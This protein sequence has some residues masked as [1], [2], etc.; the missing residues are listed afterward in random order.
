M[1]P[2]LLIAGL[3][4]A[5]VSV[6]KRDEGSVWTVLIV[7]SLLLSGAAVAGLMKLIVAL[8]I[9]GMNILAAA[10][11]VIFISLG[12][13]GWGIVTNWREQNVKRYI[14]HLL[15]IQ[16][17]I[18]LLSVSKATHLGLA[19]GVFYFVSMSLTSLLIL[20]GVGLFYENKKCV[21]E[22]NAMSAYG[23]H[24]SLSSLILLVGFSS[25]MFL[26]PF[27]G[28]SSLLNLCAAI[29]EQHSLLSLCILIILIIG[30]WFCEIKFFSMIF[31]GEKAFLSGAGLDNKENNF[32]HLFDRALLGLIIVFLL[33]G[34]LYW[35]HLIRPLEGFAKDF[36]IS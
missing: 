23:K 13:A 1:L 14:S 28:F 4:P 34:G 7:N 8:Q 16:W 25:L 24:L 3:F 5:H 10:A 30:S 27:A 11:I 2:F 18:C 29:F 17:S 32:L 33:C 6:V 35:D 15:L 12:G 9:G 19:S 20:G 36:I 31:F 22:I 21:T 26:P